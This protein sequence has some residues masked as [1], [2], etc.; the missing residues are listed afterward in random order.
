MSDIVKV[1]INGL[2]GVRCVAAFSCVKGTPD[3]DLLRKDLFGNTI[4]NLCGKW[5]RDCNSLQ[6][7]FI[8]ETEI[9]FS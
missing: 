2:I 5:C 9:E 6:P 1:P 8:E 3:G 4:S 7:F